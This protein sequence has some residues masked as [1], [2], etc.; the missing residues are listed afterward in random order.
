MAGVTR[1]SLIPFLSA[2]STT[3]RSG[4]LS[5]SVIYQEATIT[6]TAG[7]WLVKAGGALINLTTSD[8]GVA[9]IYN[10]TTSAEVSVS[11][12][13]QVTT[14]TTS[15]QPVVSVTMSITVT[16]N[17]DFC[18]LFDRSGPSTLRAASDASGA[19]GFIEAFRIN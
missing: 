13:S 19:A 16:G 9:G 17:T 14:T 1:A 15:Y 8:N 7:T 2:R 11:R 5:S 6:L 18:P 12:G 10:R 3:T 4:S